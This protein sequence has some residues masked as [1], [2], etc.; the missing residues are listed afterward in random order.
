[1][2][3][4]GDQEAQAATFHGVT[5][6]GGPIKNVQ[7]H[8]NG[9]EQKQRLL[10]DNET[11]TGRKQQADMGASANAKALQAAGGRARRRGKLRKADVLIEEMDC[12]LVRNARSGG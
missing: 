5:D 9:A 7:R 12:G 6:F 8:N 11:G 2:R 10:Q 3:D 4:V 1:V